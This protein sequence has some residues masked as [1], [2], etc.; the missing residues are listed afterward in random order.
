MMRLGALFVLHVVSYVK[1]C[2]A[3]LSNLAHR[4]ALTDKYRPET[5]CIIGNYYSLKGQHEKAVMYFR[6]ALKLNRNYL[7]AWTLMGHEFVEMKNPSAAIDAYRCRP[8][9]LQLQLLL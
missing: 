3:E 9:S 8:I 7:S 1:E 2:F 5:C 6:R 4:T